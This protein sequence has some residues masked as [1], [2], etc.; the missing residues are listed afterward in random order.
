[1][2]LNKRSR[3]SRL[4]VVLG[5]ALVVLLQ[6]CTASG[7]DVTA[8]VEIVKSPNDERS[9][10]YVELDNGLRALLVSDADADK[11]AAAL[12][13]YVGSASNPKD[14]AGLAHFL[15]HM[16]FLGTDKYP[17]PAE[18]E[19]FITEHGGHRNAYTAFEHTNYFF[20]I[21]PGHLEPALDRFAQFF[22][23][24]R[25][26][27]EYVDREVKSVQ[28]EYQM[29]LKTDPR[30]NLD[31]MREIVNPNHPFS[32]LG[33]GTRETLADRPGDSV[34]DDLLQFY[35]AYYSAN[36]MTLSILGRESLDELERMVRQRFAAVP[37]RDVVIND[38][39]QP[40]YVPGSLPMKVFIQPEAEERQLQLSFALDRDYTRNYRRKSLQ[41]LGFLVGHEGAG[42]LLSLLK[43]E[44][45]AEALGAGG[46]LSYRGG[47]A[48][49]MSITLTA[50]GMAQRERVL[51]QVFEYFNL[52]R[53]EGVD[54]AI[55]AEQAQVA[56]LQ[57]RFQEESAPMGY[58][59]SLANDMHYF[60]ASDILRGNY[61]MDDFDR[62]EIQSILRDALVADNAMVS[63]I[64]KDVP[65]D[66]ESE[67]YAT[68]Y[69]VASLR[70]ADA[71][72]L[73]VPDDRIDERLTLPAL[74][75]FIAEDVELVKIEAGNADVPMLVI[76]QPRIQ[77]WFRQDDRFRVPRGA[78]YVS[79]RNGLVRESVRDSAAAVLYT[80]LLND[81]S[82]ELTYPARVAGL[83][84]SLYK[85]SRGISL[86]VSGYNDKQQILLD[87]IVNG[88]QTIDLDSARF[89][90]VR[91]DLQRSLA[92]ART[93][94]PF[95][96]VMSASQ[97]VL[98]SGEFS[99]EELLAALDD[100]D[101]AAI[102]AFA[103][104]FWAGAQADVLVSGNYRPEFTGQ[105]AQSIALLL[106]DGDV[107]AQPPLHVVKL[108]AGETQVYTRAVDHDDAVLFW[109]VQAPAAD[110]QNR[111]QAALTGQA[112]KSGFYQQLRTEQQLGY[113]VSAF[114]F[115]VLD[116]PGIGLLVQSPTTSAA[117]LKQAIEAFLVTTSSDEG[118]SE[119]Q[120]Q[121]HQLALLNDL[122]KPDKNLFEESEY[123][124]REI[125][126]SEY[127]FASKREL[128]DAV[129]AL[130]YATWR[131]WF[132]Q[133][134]IDEPALLLTLTPGR[135]SDPVS[136]R[137]AVSPTELQ[138]RLPFYSIP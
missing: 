12:D 21:D 2:L 44:G 113:V 93:A 77:M 137:A 60:E 38:I 128:A 95:R 119:A 48:F 35:E 91:A 22:I 134:V 129:Q 110:A 29:G 73:S 116:V 125:A 96:Q 75:R 63:V 98:Q 83:N 30:R 72:W 121:R 117:G 108:P 103:A 8:A 89:D 36:L 39:E 45:W 78:L 26:D 65:V 58:V 53:R 16:L 24:P 132:Q 42:S 84:F 94:R 49:Y 112:L 123:Y 34:R 71:A 138:A 87:E 118:M 97:R 114:Y 52:L 64:G 56:A 69:S 13:I 9:Y 28:A 104:S 122:R 46:G 127:G 20:D 5:A 88:V 80:A 131:A 100:L 31:V 133:W 23:A 102:E 11:A 18:Y 25:F 62:G 19:S 4:W 111:A 136:G 37:N 55:Y 76:D 130:D 43:A 124:W 67:F 7:P 14:R 120:F 135:W 6:G 47:S 92:N 86:K 54:S 85:H 109:M 115:P 17:D 74:N 3:S 40:L 10:R 59:S 50:D 61:R 105:V 51:E 66:R 126:R 33:V 99:E 70:D 106:G 27:A 32:I 57:F 79:F 107:A 82:N 81:A 41:Y 68:P 101:P 15:E 90:N 1:M